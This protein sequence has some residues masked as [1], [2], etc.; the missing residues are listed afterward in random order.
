MI[1]IYW[2]IFIKENNIVNKSFEIPQNQDISALGANL[3]ILSEGDI[4]KESND[5]YPGIAVKQ[6]GYLPIGSCLSG[7]GDPYFINT[8]EGVNGKLY[9]VRH[10]SGTEE[11]FALKGGIEIVLNNYE[12]LLNYK[13]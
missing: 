4:L 1:P 13:R 11:N 10:E 8:K 9:R 12:E 7:S 2:N 6:F 5:Y 3:E